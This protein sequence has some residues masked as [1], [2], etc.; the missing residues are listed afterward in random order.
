MLI[1]L[2]HLPSS[3]FTE[4]NT[5]GLFD[6]PDESSVFKIPPAYLGTIKGNAQKLTAF[7]K[8]KTCNALQRLFRINFEPLEL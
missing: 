7:K 2:E 6:Q 8:A 1:I 3:N 4:I 5:S